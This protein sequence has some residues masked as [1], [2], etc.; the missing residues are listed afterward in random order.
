MIPKDTL[1][2]IAKDA[3]RYAKRCHTPGSEFTSYSE[4]LIQGFREAWARHYIVTKEVV[5]ATVEEVYR[6]CNEFRT[7]QHSSVRL[8]RDLRRT[9]I[10]CKLVLTRDKHNRKVVIRFA[11]VDTLKLFIKSYESQ[12]HQQVSLDY[13]LGRLKQCSPNIARNV[14]IDETL[15][16]LA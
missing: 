15:Y 9:G 14:F 8:E 12:Y 7:D 3:H 2:K 16:D 1:R 10:N 13:T 5:A 4:W 6:A 11:A